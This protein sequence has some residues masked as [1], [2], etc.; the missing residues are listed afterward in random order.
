MTG[1]YRGEL[2]IGTTKNISSFCIWEGYATELY[3]QLGSE[4]GK[5]IHFRVMSITVR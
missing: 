4:D 3:M 2:P 1:T 5:C